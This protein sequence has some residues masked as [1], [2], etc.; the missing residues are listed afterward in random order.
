M[1][2]DTPVYFQLIMPGEYDTSSGDYA[3]G[4][5]TETMKYA[6]VTDTG[7]DTILKV[8]GELKQNIKTVRMHGRFDAAFN[9]IRIGDKSYK[10]DF[11]RQLRNFHVFVVS[12]VQ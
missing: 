6:D 11:T 2:F 8:Y 3:E 7:T 12:E 4:T 5:K 10:V 9:R 1:R